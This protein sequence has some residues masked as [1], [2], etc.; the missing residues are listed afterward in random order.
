MARSMGWPEKGF[1]LE[2]LLK[3]EVLLQVSVLSAGATRRF[4]P[5]ATL[6]RCLRQTPPRAAQ[7]SQ[8]REGLA[9]LPAPK[10]GSY[11]SRYTQCGG[12]GGCQSAARHGRAI[13]WAGQEQGQGSLR[14]EN[15]DGPRSI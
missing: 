2:S 13:P 6:A 3:I 12:H 9:A 8:R 1:S 5:G 15:W 4:G 10:P 7:L 11:R 14:Q